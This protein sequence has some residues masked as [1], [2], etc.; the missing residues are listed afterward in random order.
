MATETVKNR[1]INH[2]FSYEVEEK[3][4]PLS[5]DE[6]FSVG[7]ATSKKMKSRGI[8]TIGN[9]AN[10]DPQLISTW[11]KKP[12]ERLWQYAWGKEDSLIKK[13]KEEQKSIGNSST[14]SFDLTS[15]DEIKKAFLGISECLGMR[16]RKEGIKG[17][18]LHISYRNNEL[19]STHFQRTLPF[20]TDRTSEIFNFSYALYKTRESDKPI[21]ALELVY[22]LIEDRCKG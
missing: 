18:T 8:K 17:K 15:E 13:T 10:T 19:V 14:F 3:M 9:L 5:I 21:K 2:I 4:W 11:L 20:F 22:D 6:L 1:G 16:M 7:S 12:G